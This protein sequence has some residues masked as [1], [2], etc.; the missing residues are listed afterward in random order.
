MA[1]RIDLHVRKATGEVSLVVHDEGASEAEHEDIARMVADQILAGA[2]VVEVRDLVTAPPPV[3][4]E[5]A[6]EPSAHVVKEGERG[7]R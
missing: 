1:I 4:P 7:R 5:G 3:Q 6:V 2:R